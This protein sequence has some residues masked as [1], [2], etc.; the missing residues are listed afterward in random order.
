MVAIQLP[1]YLSLP[2]AEPPFPGIVVVHEGGGIS[3]QLLRLSER[4]AAEGYAVCAPDFFFRSGGPEAAGFM[5]L[6]GAITPE[7]LKDDFATAIGCTVAPSGPGGGGAGTFCHANRAPGEIDSARIRSR[8]GRTRCWKRSRAAAASRWR[9]CVCS[10]SSA[11]RD[12]VRAIGEIIPVRWRTQPRGRWACLP[13]AV[14]VNGGW[15]RARSG[16]VIGTSG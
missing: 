7:Q 12:A 14:G 3:A 8:V 5:E 11:T 10:C 4:L 13:T 1:Y 9:R 15:S 16:A 6:I 2:N